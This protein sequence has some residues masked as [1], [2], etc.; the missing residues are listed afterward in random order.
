[1]ACI[2][3]PMPDRELKVERSR[4]SGQVLDSLAAAIRSGKL[5]EGER[6]PSERDLVERFGVSRASVREALLSLRAAGL[7]VPQDRSRARVARI[8]P[9]T[10]LSPLAQAAQSLLATRGGV[11]DFQEARILFECGLARHAARYASPKEVARLGDCLEANR[12]AIG[13]VETFIATDMAFHAAL[14]ENPA[15]SLFIALGQALEGWLANQRRV[16]MRARGAVRRAYGH[17]VAIY[18]AIQ[19]RSPER[20]DAAMAEHLTFVARVYREQ[21]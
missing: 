10:L 6:L 11:S 3:A 9:R 16:G 20:A 2:D 7:I 15:N 5:A 13:D 18:E 17:H 14:A 12:R 4:A 19:A 8:D 21:A 1:M